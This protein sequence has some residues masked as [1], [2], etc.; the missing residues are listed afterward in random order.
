MKVSSQSTKTVLVSAVVGLCVLAL[1]PS[2][3]A[4]NA[5]DPDAQSVLAAMSNYLGGLKSFSVE[6]STVDEVVTPE[7]Q[8]LQ[9]LHSGE[10]T[11]QRPDK[12]YAIRKGAAGTAEVF[13]DGKGLTLFAKQANAY[14]QFDAASIDAAIDVVHKV[15]FDAPGADLLASKPLD[16]S[17]T[18]MTSGAYIGMTFIDGVE[19]HQLAFR[20]AD[21]DWQLWVTAGDKPLP[22]RYVITTKSISSAPQYTLQLGNWNTAPQI[23][24]ARFTFVP[25]QGAKKL[26]ATSVTVNAIGDMTIK[27]K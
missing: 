25:P 14:L 15:G 21:V 26:D 2:A 17:T 3:R 7:G 13:L 18:D 22:L 4:Q 1:I 11:M 23:D 9:F 8:K 24:A 16:S 20:G 12:L 19:V 27:G 10:I 5:V 6:Y